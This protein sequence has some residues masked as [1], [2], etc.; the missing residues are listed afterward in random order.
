MDK[1]KKE[2]LSSIVYHLVGTYFLKKSPFDIYLL[3]NT[4]TV[5]RKEVSFSQIYQFA[6]A[7]ASVLVVCKRTN[8]A[9]TLLKDTIKYVKKIAKSTKRHYQIQYLKAIDGGTR[10]LDNMIIGLHRHRNLDDVLIDM[11]VDKII[12]SASKRKAGAVYTKYVYAEY[13]CLLNDSGVNRMELLK[14]YVELCQGVCLEFAKQC[15]EQNVVQFENSILPKNIDEDVNLLY[16]GVMHI[17]KYREIYPFFSLDSTC[18]QRNS[19]DDVFDKDEST[20]SPPK[21]K[22]AKQSWPPTFVVVDPP[23]DVNQTSVPRRESSSKPDEFDNGY[24][25]LDENPPPSNSTSD[26][27]SVSPENY[28]YQP[29]WSDH[30]SDDDDMDQS[31]TEDWLDTPPNRRKRPFPRR[32]LYMS[33]TD[34]VKSFH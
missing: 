18:Q 28:S 19:H 4:N 32:L 12:R 21:K 6:L 34:L 15:V 2:V 5:R 20:D 3:V 29:Y 7:C 25:S 1:R 27:S 30:D 24:T 11:N 9:V 13:Q 22:S 33:I 26:E 8:I 14:K 17:H 23:S 10:W 16:Y 31:Q